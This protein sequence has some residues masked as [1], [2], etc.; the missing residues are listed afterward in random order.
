MS[1]TPYQGGMPSLRTRHGPRQRGSGFFSSLKRFLLPIA[2]T[3]LPHVAG[4]VG[5]L[6]GG[7]SAMETF[8]SRGRAA[9]ADIIGKAADVIR[10]SPPENEVTSPRKGI[11]RK[12]APIRTSVSTLKK[13]KKTG[14]LSAWN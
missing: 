1:I 13:K 5:D 9:G 10:E 11:K 2:K 6:I 12:A 7:R 14:K 4:A 3:A 8:K